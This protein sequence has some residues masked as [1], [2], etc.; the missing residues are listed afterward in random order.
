[1]VSIAP[2]ASHLYP[3]GELLEV[4]VRNIAA[5]ELSAFRLLK[6]ECVVGCTRTSSI[7]NESAELA[8]HLWQALHSITTVRWPSR[9]SWPKL[10]VS[11]G[12]KSE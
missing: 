7:R 1:M 8:D 10:V 3:S 9:S 5:S 11:G 6:Y 2:Q 12:N 4:F